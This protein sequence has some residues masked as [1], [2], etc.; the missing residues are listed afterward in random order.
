M[1]STGHVLS[2]YLFLKE[3]LLYLMLLCGLT[4]QCWQADAQPY[5]YQFNHLTVNE[6]LSHTDANCIAQDQKGYVW[7]GTLFGINRFDGYT[8]KRY[9]NS[10]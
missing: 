1:S 6:G 3:R 4:L 8:V 7:I 5:A 10:L 9:Y 2:A